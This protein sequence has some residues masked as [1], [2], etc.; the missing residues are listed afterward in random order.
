MRDIATHTRV[1]PNQ[2]I[3]AMK[4][5]CQ[6]VKENEKACSLLSNWGLAL[7]DHPI[8]LNARNLGDEKIIFGNGK[9]VS[10]GPMANFVKHV[11]NTT[12]FDVVNIMDWLLIHPRSERKYADS[13][14]ACLERIASPMG[15]TIVK[16]NICV[17]DDD[18][19]ETYA[20]KL[21][22]RLSAK[23][24]IVV[25]ICPTSRDDRYAAIKKLCCAEMPIPSQVRTKF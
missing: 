18:K 13:F 6:N 15:I 21:R 1:T 10:A 4:K 20:R 22:E 24:Q 14:L 19:T 5:F 17:L 11:A 7:D 23:T 9:T 3:A 16:P 25:I 12:L 2:R 8:K